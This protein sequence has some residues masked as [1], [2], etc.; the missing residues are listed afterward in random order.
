M[1]TLTIGDI[2]KRGNTKTLANK[3]F[4][5]GENNLFSTEEGAFRATGVLIGNEKFGEWE[6]T[7]GNITRSNSLMS[8]N[9]QYFIE[10]TAGSLP[11]ELLGSYPPSRAKASV[12]ITKVIKTE[13][14]GGHI[15]EKENKGIRFERDFQ[16]SL[17]YQMGTRKSK[18]PYPKAAEGL[19]NKIKKV[20]GKR[21]ALDS[22]IRG[23]ENQ[24]RP[25]GPGP[26]VLP[27][28]HRKHGEKLTDIDLKMTGNTII[29]L[30]LKFGATLTFMN[31][32]VSKIFTTEQIDAGTISTPIGKD[33]ENMLALDPQLFGDTFSRYEQGF[34]RTSQDITTKVD[35]KKLRKFLETAMGSNYWMVHGKENGAVSFWYMDSRNIS[36]LTA[37]E[38]MIKIYYGGKAGPAKRVD[39]EFSNQYFD[40]KIN[41]RSKT[42][43][44]VYPTHMMLDYKSKNVAG[45][46]TTVLG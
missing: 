40:F 14:F 30:S 43:G 13:E 3:I 4:K 17:L 18:G 34:K 22:T 27:N 33:L 35:R 32:G 26:L 2:R 44:G 16:E 39:I 38:G 7:T 12:L 9:L 25:L 23:G 5:V 11:I 1:A 28:D 45:W 21:G 24:P 46:K 19:I 41:Y 20:T 31:S 10:G 37:L 15:G 36:N 8:K 42:G 29:P 6:Y